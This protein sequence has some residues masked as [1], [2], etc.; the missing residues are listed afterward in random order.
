MMAYFL[1]QRKR[2]GECG[3]VGFFIAIVPK[4]A[5]SSSFKA[6]IIPAATGFEQ[7]NV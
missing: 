5:H 6:A 1:G 2:H 7:P 3:Q 4:I